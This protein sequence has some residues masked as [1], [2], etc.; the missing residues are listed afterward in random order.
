[1]AL[2]LNTQTRYVWAI[3]GRKNSPLTKDFK[4][5]Y[6]AIAKF[7]NSGNVETY[8]Y[9][10]HDKDIDEDGHPKFR[11][12]HLL[13]VFKEGLKPRLSTTL[14][15]LSQV[16]GVDTLDIDLQVADNVE[17]CIRYCVHR[18]W[19]DKY[20]YNVN[21][22]QTNLDASELDA[23]LTT[24]KECVTASYLITCCKVNGFS[25]VAIMR[26]LGL[27]AYMKYRNAIRDICEELIEPR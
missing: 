8:A 23:I 5:Y 21:D 17:G 10:G 19:N 2:N 14:N 24:E 25:S 22:M 18:G 9:I 12:I 26:T 16:T 1:M 4:E 13:I 7:L 6:D 15:R 11:H 27:K 3:L 20:Q